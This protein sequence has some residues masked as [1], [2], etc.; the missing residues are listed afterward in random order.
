MKVYSDYSARFD[1]K[2]NQHLVKHKFNVQSSYFDILDFFKWN[3]ERV[4][5]K[6][7]FRSYVIR[8]KKIM[9]SWNSL[10]W[11]IQN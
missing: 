9:R 1:Q 5:F 11:I 10:N 7:V 3:Y 4:F 8:E 2:K 6:I